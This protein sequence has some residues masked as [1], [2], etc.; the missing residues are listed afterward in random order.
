MVQVVIDKDGTLDMVSGDTRQLSISLLDSPFG[1]V[2]GGVMT[3]YEEVYLSVVLVSISDLDASAVASLSAPSQFRFTAVNYATPQ[4]ITVTATKIL[5]GEA[6]LRIVAQTVLKPRVFSEGASFSPGNV[7]VETLLRAD[8]VAPGFLVVGGSSAV[9]SVTLEKAMLADLDVEL[10]LSGDGVNVV[11]GNELKATFPANTLSTMTFDVVA[12][13]GS[14]P[15]SGVITVD[16]QLSGANYDAPV[17]LHGL[18][19]ITV[20]AATDLF[21]LS[22]P[23]SQGGTVQLFAGEQSTIVVQPTTPFLAGATSVEAYFLVDNETPFRDG[24]YLDYEKNNFTDS[25][26]HTVRID[27]EYN[28]VVAASANLGGL[29]VRATFTDATGAT[30]ELLLPVAAIAVNRLFDIQL[31]SPAVLKADASDS[32]AA[33]VYLTFALDEAIDVQLFIGNGDLML[34]LGSGHVT[35]TRGDTVNTFRPTTLALAPTVDSQ[36]YPAGNYSVDATFTPADG[37]TGS[38]ARTLY[39]LGVVT[40]TE[41]AA[42]PPDNMYVEVLIDGEDANGN[43]TLKAGQTV[44]VDVRLNRTP[45]DDTVTVYLN[46]GDIGVAFLQTGAGS[47]SDSQNMFAIGSAG[48]YTPIAGDGIVVLTF[49]KSN[50]AQFATI[51]LTAVGDIDVNAAERSTVINIVA[52]S[53]KETTLQDATYL[54][55][56][57]VAVDPFVHIEVESS[58]PFAIVG[59]SPIQITATLTA[60]GGLAA[61]NGLEIQITVSGGFQFTTNPAKIAFPPGSVQ[62]TQVQALVSITGYPSGN[63]VVPPALSLGALVTGDSS[64][65]PGLRLTDL[66]FAQVVNVLDIL[67]PQS[68]WQ[69]LAA[70]DPST[71]PSVTLYLGEQKDITAS[72]IPMPS[73]TVTTVGFSVVDSNNQPSTGLLSVLPSASSQLYWNAANHTVDQSLTLSAAGASG[74]APLQ[75]MVNVDYKNGTAPLTVPLGHVSVAR[76]VTIIVPNG[77]T[78]IPGG[79][80]VAA[81]VKLEVT[82]PLTAPL[83]IEL[84]VQGYTMAAGRGEVSFLVGEKVGATRT[85]MLELVQSPSDVNS[86]AVPINAKILSMNSAGSSDPLMLYNLA[87]V[88]ILVDY[89]MILVI[90]APWS[91]GRVDM[92]IGNTRELNVTLYTRPSYGETVTV[93]F[94]TVDPNVAIADSTLLRFT[95]NNYNVPRTINVHVPL[96]ASGSTDL[97]FTVNSHSLGT[98]PAMRV[99]TIVVT[100]LIQVTVNTTEPLVLGG[101]ARPMEIKLLGQVDEDLAVTITSSTHNLDEPLPVAE[102]DGLASGTPRSQQPDQVAETPIAVDS[103]KPGTQGGDPVILDA[104]LVQ[105][106]NGVYDGVTLKDV[107]RASIN[108]MWNSLVVS[109]DCFDDADVAVQRMRLFAGQSKTCSVVLQSDPPN[110]RSYA[111]LSFS[112]ADPSTA[113]VVAGTSL[114]FDKTNWQVPQTVT[115]QGGPVLSAITQLNGNGRFV[116]PG[117]ADDVTAFAVCD[118]QVRGLIQAVIPDPSFLI[119][120]GSGFSVDLVLELGV[121]SDGPDLDL[122]VI[123]PGFIAVG[124]INV[125]FPAGSLAGTRRTAYVGATSQQATSNRQAYVGVQVSGAYPEFELHGLASVR[126]LGLLEVFTLNSIFLNG[127]V[128]VFAG[129]TVV[130]DLDLLT[131]HDTKAV[132]SFVTSDQSVAA[133]RGGPL[134]FEPGVRQLT[135]VSFL[136]VSNLIHLVR[137]SDLPLRFCSFLILYAMMLI[138]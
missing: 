102:F 55:I 66:A 9:V 15:T 121:P 29:T 128:N 95:E 56:S 54:A 111:V 47:P 35:F 60:D 109:V 33:N 52:D 53:D 50:Y 85:V 36:N 7:T 137:L 37:S 123:L 108:V 97:V 43:V 2:E 71:T 11:L 30:F 59:G 96:G 92:Q 28:E 82:T 18:T 25:T 119:I 133:L 131:T 106:N 114:F 84:I 117:Q 31:A 70:A 132:V 12:L 40:I 75:V 14:A 13:A 113:T 135:G 79:A 129:E 103:F 49:D 69:E 34:R 38:N 116:Q 39:N 45:G 21:T 61:G 130:L 42:P 115:I 41:V 105:P 91:S 22:A 136:I 5:N 20:V 8:V 89:S 63:V 98:M 57:T 64:V 1:I 24:F 10:V 100:S 77:G 72:L 19:T 76:L 87:Q 90:S 32:L 122:Q 138:S 81:T 83:S 94:D 17:V 93:V 65:F 23:W 73:P 74:T 104:V 46:T 26:P 80:G 101:P 125:V 51:Y 44:T 78:I 86:G 6:E 3:A 88:N 110:D 124:D 68:P 62:G 112:T 99:C 48:M 58:A 120:G 126:V 127:V 118:V 67:A 27:T 4:T 107:G 134:T 16:L